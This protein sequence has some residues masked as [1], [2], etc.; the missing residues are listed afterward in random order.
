MILYSIEAKDIE[1]R[2]NLEYFCKDMDFCLLLKIIVK[3]YV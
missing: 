3:I 1:L 2:D